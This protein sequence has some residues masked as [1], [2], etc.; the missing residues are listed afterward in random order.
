MSP[1]IIGGPLLLAFLIVIVTLRATRAKVTMARASPNRLS[2]SQTPVVASRELLSAHRAVRPRDRATRGLE[3]TLD[4]P[5]S[6]G[7]RV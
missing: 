5:A 2:S 7:F 3:R 4:W 1:Q 6:V